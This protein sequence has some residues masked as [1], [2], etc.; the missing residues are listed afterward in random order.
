MSKIRVVPNP[1]NIGDPLVSGSTYGADTQ[2]RLLYFLNL[3]AV[4]TIKIFTENG[5][6]VKT[7]DHT[8]PGGP[9]GSA[10]WNLDT[11]SGQLVS[12]GIYI[13][14]FQTPAG[15]SSYQKFVIVR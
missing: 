10:Q 15:G 12:S 14:V 7:I 9:S 1:Y 4:C 8:S 2:G 6:L 5:D 11:S 3:P 13:A